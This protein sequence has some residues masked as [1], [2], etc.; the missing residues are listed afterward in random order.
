MSIDQK[1]FDE[2]DRKRVGPEGLTREEADELGRMMAEREGKPYANADDVG[3]QGE[4]VQAH[5]PAEGEGEEDLPDTEDELDEWRRA[6]DS[7][8]PEPT[9]GT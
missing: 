7:G 8:E 4:S 3:P 9:S 2:L 1:R 6:P 5:L